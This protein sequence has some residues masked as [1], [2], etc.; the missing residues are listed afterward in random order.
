[1]TEEREKLYDRVMGK[2]VSRTELTGTGGEPLQIN[3]ITGVNAVD[4]EFVEVVDVAADAVNALPAPAVGVEAIPVGMC[5]DDA[6]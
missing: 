1:M 6:K 5:G 3:V 4:A 2:A